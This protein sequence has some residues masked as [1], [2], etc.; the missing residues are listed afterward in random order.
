MHIFS[1]TFYLEKLL[2]KQIIIDR[3]NIIIFAFCNLSITFTQT[4]DINANQWK[5]NYT[6]HNWN[7]LHCKYVKRHTESKIRV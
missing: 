7:S 4:N 3:M 2:K 1:E 6:V 5:S